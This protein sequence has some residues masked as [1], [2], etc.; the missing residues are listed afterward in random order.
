[1]KRRI[2]YFLI[3]V[4]HTGIAFA[5][6]KFDMATF[7]VPKGW[8]MTKTSETVILQKDTRK[9]VTCKIIIS[10]TEKGAVNTVTEYLQA[11]A[12]KGGKGI[13]YDNKKG[14]VVKYEA[15]GLISFFSKGS[16]TEST[17]P[18]YSYFYSLSNGRQTFY[19]QLLTSNNGC[20]DEFNQF[21]TELKMD[22]ED[23]G[24]QKA[25]KPGERGR[26]SSPATPAAPAPIM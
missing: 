15:D 8:Q 11:R 3:A 9:E 25:K 2:I 19:Y 1:M 26:R 4:L 22:T 14:A 6:E 10:A 24:S 13:N 23:E 21:M 7:T 20:I 18:V 12:I 17:T 5:Q 16:V